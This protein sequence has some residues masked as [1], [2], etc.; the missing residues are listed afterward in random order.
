M[1]PSVAFVVFSYVFGICEA[2]MLSA[3]KLAEA[4]V[5]VDIYIDRNSYQQA[6]PQFANS[7]VRLLPID[8]VG[9]ESV[10]LRKTFATD[11]L[12]LEFLKV[13]RGFPKFPLFVSALVGQMRVKRYGLLIGVEPFGLVAAHLAT[14]LQP[15]PLVYYNL[16]L[17]QRHNCD[18]AEAHLV[19]D[20]ETRAA[21]AASFTVIPDA[22]RGA[23]FTRANGT[24]EERLRYLPIATSGAPLTAKSDYFRRRFSIPQDHLIALYAGN[25]ADWACCAE[26]A[27]ACEAW[28]ENVELV[29]HTWRPNMENDPYCQKVMRLAGPRTHL[30][31]EPLEREQFLG[32]VCSADIGLAFYKPIDE[33]FM[34]I[35]SSSNKLS[36]YFRAGLPAV[37]S[38]FPSVLAIFERYGCG[39]CVDGPQSA[40]PALSALG[41]DLARYRAA[42]FEAYEA[43][44]CF[45]PHFEPLLAEFK[46]MLSA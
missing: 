35:G 8:P 6:P 5:D 29:I 39:L 22:E 33:N 13:N 3:S 40:G 19:K 25:L 7:R 41:Q 42:A 27:E 31:L 9:D 38:N 20:M 37:T 11:P 45:D 12:F 32:A 28:P 4:D 21:L 1:R 36:L 43:H 24:Q 14:A 34:E 23:V 17:Y 18:C 30:S 26:M 16:E 44:Y 46:A 2:L 10:N 15:A